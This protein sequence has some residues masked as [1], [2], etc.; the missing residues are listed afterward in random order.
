MPDAGPSLPGAAVRVQRFLVAWDQ[1]RPKTIDGN[2]AVLVSWPGTSLPSL[3]RGDLLAL[4][5]AATK[6]SSTPGG[7]T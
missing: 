1:Y 4:I 3:Y 7:S 6:G 5:E 2:G